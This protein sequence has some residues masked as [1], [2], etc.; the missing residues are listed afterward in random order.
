MFKILFGCPP[1]TGKKR[2]AVQLNLLP[3]VRAMRRLL[4]LTG[5]AILSAA[6]PTLG[7]DEQQ[8]FQGKELSLRIK[9]CSNLIERDPKD[10]TALHNRAVAFGMAGDLD[11]AIADYSK[12]IEIA[13]YIVSAYENRGRVHASRGEQT[14]AL[15]DATRASELVARAV[16]EPRAIT[17]KKQRKRPKVT[18]A[19]TKVA[20]ARRR[21]MIT[22]KPSDI[23]GKEP[24]GTW[25]LWPWGIGAATRPPPYRQP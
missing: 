16:A 14:L 15:A 9:G 3:G 2:F 18:P 20:K 8:C 6:A 25:L 13:P 4:L 24:S 19:A 21:A 22:T 7:N 1:G 23:I 17:P 12:V 11:H 10:A 5:V